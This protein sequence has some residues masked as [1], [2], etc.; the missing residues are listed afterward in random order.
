MPNVTDIADQAGVNHA[1]IGSVLSR[2]NSHDYFFLKGVKECIDG[3]K[4][5]LATAQSTD[6]TPANVGEKISGA[7]AHDYYILRGLAEL[8]DAKGF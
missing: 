7:T 3:T 2:A 6:C 1:N 8:F 4:D 5:L